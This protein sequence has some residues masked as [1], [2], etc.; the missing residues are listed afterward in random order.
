MVAVTGPNTGGKTASLKTLGLASVM[1]KAG[2][3]LPVKEGGEQSLRITWFDKVGPR[4][5]IGEQLWS[6]LAFRC[7]LP[8]T[9][10]CS[11]LALLP[12]GFSRG[13]GFGGKGGGRGWRGREENNLD[14]WVE[15]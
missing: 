1:A 11:R 12:I 3:F 14:R 2:L 5:N 4:W 8:T 10:N 6:P 13:E 9:M 15:R 7:F